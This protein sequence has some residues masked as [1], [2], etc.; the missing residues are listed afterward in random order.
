ML[1][2][3]MIDDE[4]GEYSQPSPLGLLH[5]A[6]EIRHRAEI[7]IDGAVVGNVIAVVTAGRGIEWQQPKRRDA[8]ILQI[9]EL[10]GQ[11]C[12]IA[13]AIVIAVGESLDMKLIDD[14]VLEPK[15]IAFEPRRRPDVSDHIHGTAFTRSSGTAGRG[16]A[17][18]RCANGLR[19]TRGHAVRP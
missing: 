19:P 18:H 13:D 14:R 10:F 17:A 9:V 16:P 5:E 12:E 2:G 8:E 4:L 15:L 3:R 1:V 7:G 11:P 6:T